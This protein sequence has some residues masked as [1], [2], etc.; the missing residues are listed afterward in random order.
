[1]D[2]TPMKWGVIF[3]RA[4]LA[5]RLEHRTCNAMV[6]GSIPIAGSFPFRS[7]HFHNPQS[8]VRIKMEWRILAVVC[9]ALITANTMTFFVDQSLA[10][11]LDQFIGMILIAGEIYFI[12][13]V[14]LEFRKGNNPAAR[15][16]L[17]FALFAWSVTS[18]YMSADVFY[19]V[20]MLVSTLSMFL[21]FMSLKTEAEV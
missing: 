8:F 6:I 13:D 11:T 18:M 2:L 14:L 20:S 1:M 5:Q 19:L 12:T 16:S 7:S 17:A 21:M 3:H 9:I 10:S 4:C 15:I